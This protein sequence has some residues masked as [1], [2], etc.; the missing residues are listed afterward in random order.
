MYRDILRIPQL[1]HAVL[2]IRIAL[3]AAVAL[4]AVAGYL[5]LSPK[6]K[7]ASLL[8]PPRAAETAC[9]MDLEAIG[10]TLPYVPMT[11][12][13]RIAAHRQLRMAYAETDDRVCREI[14]GGIVRRFVLR[15][16][17]GER[18]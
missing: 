12:H 3:A 11:F 14:G 7:Q 17:H 2:A 1:C 10:R 8:P 4:L 15:N 5:V 9:H 13:E 16:V 6:P 18:L